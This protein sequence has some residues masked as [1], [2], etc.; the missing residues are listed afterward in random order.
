MN[1]N[2]PSEIIESIIRAVGPILQESEL[3]L[4]DVEF[5]PSGKRWLLRIYIDRDGG[6]TL[7]D[8]ERVSRELGRLLDV[9]DIIDHAYALEVSSPG[10]T[11]PLKTRADFERYKGKTCRIVTRSTVEGKIEFRGEIVG[12]KEEDV[13]V[14][15]QKDTYSIPLC[16]I[17]KANLEFDV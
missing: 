11:R 16:V 9:E 8:C 3:D 7:K 6:V 13:E 10:L 2:T 12:V 4:V 17:K 5:R 15:D 1:D 14:R